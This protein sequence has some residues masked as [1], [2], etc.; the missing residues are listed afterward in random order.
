MNE[1]LAQRPSMK[2]E[3]F[4]VALRAVPERGVL[5]DAFEAH[6]EEVLLLINQNRRVGVATLQGS[7][8]CSGGDAEAEGI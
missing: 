3:P 7:A 2:L 5:A 6:I 8:F 1:P 4:E